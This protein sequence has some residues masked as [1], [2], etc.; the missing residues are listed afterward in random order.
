MFNKRV[1]PFWKDAK[2][3]TGTVNQVVPIDPFNVTN[4]YINYTV[5]NGS[6]FDQTKF[7]LSFNNLFN[8]DNI[9]GVSQAAKANVYT[10]G[11]N[12][13]L[14]LLPPRSVTLTVT[15]GYAPKR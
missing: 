1:G 12:D 8:Q 3:S 2:A 7:K 11:P 4:F 15:F 9:V 6:H 14:T 5:R 13:N 10:P